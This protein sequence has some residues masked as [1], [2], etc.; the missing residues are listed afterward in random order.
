MPVALL[1]GLVERVAFGFR[2]VA[3]GANEISAHFELSCRLGET[4][5][6]RLPVRYLEVS[7]HEYEV[8]VGI[9]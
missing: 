8:L 2:I 9:V 4:R 5:A 3:V 1:H 6:S 7:R